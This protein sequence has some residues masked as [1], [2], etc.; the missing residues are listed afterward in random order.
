MNYLI[1]AGVFAFGAIALIIEARRN[2]RESLR[3]APFKTYPILEDAKIDELC[4]PADGITGFIIY[5]LLYLG[6][7]VVILSS[8]ELYDLIRSANLAKLVH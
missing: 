6:S 7:Y 4:T 1:Y 2:Y 5:S 3:Q 8:A